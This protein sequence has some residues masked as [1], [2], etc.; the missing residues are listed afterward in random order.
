[1]KKLTLKKVTVSALNS[2]EQNGVL[3]GAR[4]FTYYPGDDCGRSAAFTYVAACPPTY[5]CGTGDECGGG[6][7]PPPTTAH[8]CR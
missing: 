1:M 6:G 4:K 3:G 2:I 8:P 5:V 7:N